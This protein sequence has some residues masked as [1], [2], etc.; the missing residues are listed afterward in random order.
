MLATISS[1]VLVYGVRLEFILFGLT[2]L[3]ITLFHH[4]TSEVALTSFLAI[5]LY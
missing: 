1:G 4:H 5:T 3:G 2:Q